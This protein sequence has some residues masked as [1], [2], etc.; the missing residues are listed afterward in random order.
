M[1]PEA[2]GWEQARLTELDG[3]QVAVNE[4]FL[5]NPQLVLGDMGATNGAYHADDLVVRATGDPRRAQL[6]QALD[7]LAA[8]ARTRG[9][10]WTAV[11]A[12]PDPATAPARPPQ[13][14]PDGFIRARADGTFTHV[15]DGAETTA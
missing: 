10:T 7:I 15:I 1:T 6:A 13:Q 12:E 2:T 5:A 3:A 11:P 9:L 8:S 4:Y 14:E